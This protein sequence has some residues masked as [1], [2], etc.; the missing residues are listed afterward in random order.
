[1]REEPVPAIKLEGVCADYEN[2]RALDD[3]NLTVNRREFLGIIGPNGGGKSTLLKVMLGLLKPT[4]GNVMILGKDIY[5][6]GE[7][8]P[9]G[10]VPQA[11]TF[12]R[13]FPISV[14]DVVLMGRLNGKLKPFHNFSRE[15]RE[16]T[17]GIMKRLNLYEF[18]KRQ[19]GQLS[20]GQLQRVLIARALAVEPQ[21]LFL[22]EPTASLDTSSRNQ[23]YDILRDLNRE[24]TIVVVTHDMGA[25]SSYFQT[26][27][28]LNRSLHYHGNTQLTQD[29]ID[30]TYGCPIDLIAHGVP[31]RILNI[32]EKV[33]HD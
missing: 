21:I 22:D 28:C 31:H 27:A 8:L 26:I 10:Y 2:L 19:I 13:N 14:C 32:D 12:D 5:R 30:A 23:I 18:R 3:I 9:I 20:G 16:L 1:M 25:V 33:H 4:R 15:D 7:N 17:A 29:V 6:Y 11:A 24:I